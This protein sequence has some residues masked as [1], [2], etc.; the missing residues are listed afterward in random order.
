MAN[1]ALSQSGQSDGAAWTDAFQILGAGNT[2][3]LQAQLHNARD[4]MQTLTLRLVVLATTSGD[5]TIR[6]RT[7]PDPGVFATANLPESG[8]GISV[9]SF[10]D[11]FS[12]VTSADLAVPLATGA[13]SDTFSNNFDTVARRFGVSDWAG[14]IAFSI[15]DTL[16]APVGVN[17]TDTVVV[18]AVVPELSGLVGP[19]GRS[20]PD[21]C[22]KCGHASLRETW[23]R[24]GYTRQLVC[25]DCWDPP[26]TT[27]RVVRRQ[28][29]QL[30]ND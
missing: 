30:I 5:V 6:V 10:T 8:T 21:W 24:D 14:R 25:V 16:A 27:G 26:D 1:L 12:T 2:V 3:G 4:V 13:N 11:P 20:R 15:T 22:P 18:V 19:F 17:V 7:E 23:I 29:R 28:K 9:A